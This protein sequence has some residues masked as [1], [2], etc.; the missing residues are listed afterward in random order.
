MAPSVIECWCSLAQVRSMYREAAEEVMARC[1]GR[2]LVK[3]SGPHKHEYFYVV[4]GGSA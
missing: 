3:V 4:V 1:S 2:G